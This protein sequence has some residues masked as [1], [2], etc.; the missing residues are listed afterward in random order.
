MGP[1]KWVVYSCSM[2]DVGGTKNGIKGGG[3]FLTFG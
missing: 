1:Q 2:F 3:S